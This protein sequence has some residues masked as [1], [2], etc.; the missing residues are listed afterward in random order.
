MLLTR[1]VD[2]Q[3]RAS[4][5]DQRMAERVRKLPQQCMVSHVSMVEVV[6]H[7]PSVDSLLLW[8]QKLRNSERGS[9]S[10]EYCE[11]RALM[12]TR[13]CL[14]IDA[15]P[16]TARLLDLLPESAT[17]DA[18]LHIR[19]AHTWR[20]KKNQRAIVKLDA[21]QNCTRRSGCGSG[22]RSPSQDRLEHSGRSRSCSV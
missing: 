4:F 11:R 5:A 17:H 2:I 13:R 7:L 12:I 22:Q 14:A 3:F 9:L 21:A 15:D 20:R 8:R 1:S 19:A 18:N 16:D 6:A 10:I